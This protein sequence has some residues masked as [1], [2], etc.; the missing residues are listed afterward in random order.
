[1]R[2]FLLII[3]IAE[4]LSAVPCKETI[5]YF[6]AWSD[7]ELFQEINLDCIDG[8]KFRVLSETYR[9]KII[10]IEDNKY[11]KKGKIN[12]NKKN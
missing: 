9:R 8:Y 1:M 6:G 5:R 10:E 4:I 11:L 7:S 12:E 2:N 3:L